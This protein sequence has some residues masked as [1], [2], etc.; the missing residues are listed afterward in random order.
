MDVGVASSC[1][2]AKNGLW[3]FSSP[4]VQRFGDALDARAAQRREVKAEAAD[5]VADD[6]VEIV[7]ERNHG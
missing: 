3:S 7:F 5:G 1:Q 4:T 2:P 6:V